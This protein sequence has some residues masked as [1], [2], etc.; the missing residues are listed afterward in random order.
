MPNVLGPGTTAAY[1]TLTSGTAGTTAALSGLISI[2][3]N[4]RSTTFADVTAL[5]DTKMQRVPVRND[6]GTVQFTLYLD[7]TATVSNLL[8]LLDARRTGRVHTRV[9]VDLGGANID[10]IAVYDGYISEIGYP[11]IGATDEA[12]RFTVTMQLSDKSNV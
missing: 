3:A 7:D 8:T 10:T 11:D 1:A 4:A 6:P 9:T 2:A 12:L 5:S